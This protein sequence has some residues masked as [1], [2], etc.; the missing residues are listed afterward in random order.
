MVPAL[1]AL[2]GLAGSPECLA[3]LSGQDVV[4]IR[5]VIYRQISALKKDNAREAYS[6]ASPQL[7]AAFRSP[8]HFMRDART[9]YAPLYR[10]SSMAFRAVWILDNEIVQQVSVTDVSGA[11]WSAFYPMERQ[12]DGSWKTHGLRLVSGAL[13][14]I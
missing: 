12:K 2:A 11:S 10:S 7:R 8:E 9:S 6:L 5:A 4:E 13:R 14:S 1:A 3:G